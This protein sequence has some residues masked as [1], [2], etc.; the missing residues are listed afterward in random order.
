MPTCSDF[1]LDSP[2]TTSTK[3]P[4]WSQHFQIRR[5]LLPR[6][7]VVQV[8]PGQSHAPLLLHLQGNSCVQLACLPP[9]PP[10]SQ[11]AQ[12]ASAQRGTEVKFLLERWELAW[13]NSSSEGLEIV[14]EG[15]EKDK[16]LDATPQGK[17]SSGA[18]RIVGLP[19]WL[20]CK[21]S[22][23]C[24][25]R[26]GSITDLGRSHMLHHN[27]WACALEPGSHKSWAHVP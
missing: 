22:V 2:H 14:L 18:S 1:R 8:L 3:K 20:S 17:E 7:C 25:R 6:L 4:W 9:H 24:C 12:R 13:G 11:A 16:E 10:T 27:Y 26:H 5:P 21:E 23:C 19:L 15:M